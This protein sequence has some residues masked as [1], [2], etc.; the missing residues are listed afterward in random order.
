MDKP[1]E[2]AFN[3]FKQQ[4]DINSK[5]VAAL[6]RL[7]QALRIL[8]WN[9]A[10]EKNLSP[11]QIQFLLYLSNHPK[12]RRRVSNL[13]KE[14]G[15]TQATVSDTVKA[16][17]EKGLIS[18]KPYQKDGRVSTLELTSSGKRL[19][20]K[21]SGWQTAFKEQIKQFSP[22]T[23]ETVIIFL[24]ELITSLQRAGIISIA[25]MCIVC[26]FFQRDVHP[27]SESPHFCKLTNRPIANSELKIDCD[28]HKPIKTKLRK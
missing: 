16:L 19:V 24:M 12:E 26:S 10:K 15:L 2:S 21:L 22:E 11:I 25:R 7:S 9:I 3:S 18:K 23:K 27:G 28:K 6:E 20:V 17:M 4:Q 5:I 1:M 8:L 14:F 13:A